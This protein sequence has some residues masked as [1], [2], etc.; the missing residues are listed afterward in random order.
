M[1]RRQISSEETDLI[2][3][4]LKNISKNNEYQIP[5]YVLEM[6]DGGMG[7]IRLNAGKHHKD[8]IQVGYI[9]LDGQ[10]VIITLTE[11]E[12]KELFELEFWKVDFTPLKKFP[13]PAEVF[14]FQEE[15]RK[16]YLELPFG[17]ITLSGSFNNSFKIDLI[18]L[19]LTADAFFGC[20]K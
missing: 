14:S 3:S 5:N 8:L 4:L 13:S 17:N 10:T 18:N 20:T 1:I 7:S 12:N 6:D 19:V 16:A 9:D 11:S 15:V 2:A